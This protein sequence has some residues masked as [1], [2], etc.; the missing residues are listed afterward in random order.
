[1]DLNEIELEIFKSLAN[2]YKTI[3]SHLP[4][5]RVKKREITGVGMY[6][7]IAYINS[8]ISLIDIEP[9][10]TDISTNE[11][12]TTSNLKYGICYEVDIS[13]GKINFIEFVTYGE[14][15]DGT[16]PNYRFTP[17]NDQNLKQ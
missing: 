17:F 15:W 6:V 9:K 11:T 8:V 12:I 4:Y 14:E 1:M 10:N 7:E 2:K 16:F 3:F 5:I 13:E